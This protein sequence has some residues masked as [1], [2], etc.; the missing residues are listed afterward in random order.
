MDSMWR[1]IVGLQGDV[2]ATAHEECHFGVQDPEAKLAQLQANQVVMEELGE[3]IK[4]NDPDQHKEIEEHQSLMEKLLHRLGTSSIKQQQKG[5]AAKQCQLQLKIHVHQ[6]LKQKDI[7][8]LQ[9]AKIEPPQ[10]F[11]GYEGLSNLQGK[12]AGHCPGIVRRS[13]TGVPE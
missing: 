3:K 13:H 6:I 1:E 8:K 2:E 10:F 4:D 11:G 12:L 9:L 7:Q 5:L